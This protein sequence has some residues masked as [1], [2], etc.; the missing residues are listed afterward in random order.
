MPP[1]KDATC[2][3]AT[4]WTAAKLR[5]QLTADRA[6]AKAKAKALQRIAKSCAEATVQH[7]PAP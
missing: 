7:K 4:D 6:E 1:A 3:Y 2:T 5:W